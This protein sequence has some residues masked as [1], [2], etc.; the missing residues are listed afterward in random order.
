MGAV[1]P[2][3]PTG[4]STTYRL[5]CCG[6]RRRGEPSGNLAFERCTPRPTHVTVACPRNTHNSALQRD[7][8]YVAYAPPVLRDTDG[9]AAL[10]LAAQL[11][12]ERQCPFSIA[13]FQRGHQQLRFLHALTQV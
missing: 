6:T 2:V 1:V 4:S 3:A 5:P 9:P 12:L 10:P 7:A 11:L 13:I 8:A